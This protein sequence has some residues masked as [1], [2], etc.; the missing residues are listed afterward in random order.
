MKKVL[1]YIFSL[2]IVIPLSLKGQDS[3][4]LFNSFGLGIDISRIAVQFI[5][6]VRAVYSGYFD[7]QLKKNYF[8]GIEAGL[9][10]V[11][12]DKDFYKYKSDGYFFKAGVN[13]NFLRTKNLTDKDFGYLSL[14]YCYSG[15]NQSANSISFKNTYWGSSEIMVPESNNTAHWIELGGGLDVS[16]FNNLYIGWAVYGRIIII[17]PDYK[18]MTPYNIP[19]FGDGSKN[20][21]FG[22][23]YNIKYRITL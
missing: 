2:L 14:R 7:I 13:K 1:K 12:I 19:G 9:Q 16:F 8:L 20:L 5:E 4:K 17:K 10:N 6:P 21:N 23:S 3:L 11:D 15:F 22:V 18:L